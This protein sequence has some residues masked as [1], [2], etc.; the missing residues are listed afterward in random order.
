[1]SA[2][3]VLF[4]GSAAIVLVVGVCGAWPAL[5][6]PV[7]DRLRYLEVAAL[8]ATG[9]VVILYTIETRDLRVATERQLATATNPQLSVSLDNGSFRIS[10]DGPVIARSVVLRIVELP[11]TRAAPRDPKRFH[12][13]T[14]ATIAPLKSATTSVKYRVFEGG[15]DWAGAD[16][17]Q[18]LVHA[19]AGNLKAELTFENAL[20]MLVTKRL[21]FTKSS[22]HATIS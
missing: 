5:A 1:V 15:E 3:E 16:L 11:E 12:C 9:L 17:W 10:N 4:L 7:E 13:P 20:G 14:I 6:S 19:T 2:R 22:P 18:A 21:T 8:L